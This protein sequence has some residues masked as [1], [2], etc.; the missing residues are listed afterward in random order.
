MFTRR[1]GI[2]LA[3][4]LFLGTAAFLA[5]LAAERDPGEGWQA[6]NIFVPM[7]SGYPEI[8]VILQESRL[9][10]HP[11]VFRAL[12]LGTATGRHLQSGEYA[13]PAPP[14]AFEVWRKLVRGEVAR[15]S[16]TIPEGSN[17]HD[18]AKILGDS[19]L[20]DPDA[21]V[22]AARSAELAA[23]LDVPGDTVEGFLFPD[24]Y[25]LVKYM[26][27]NEIIG[28]MVRQFRRRLAPG[29]EEKG[30]LAGFSLRQIVT[31]ASII[32]KETGVPEEKPLVSAVIRRR[33][34][35]GMP[36]QMDPTVI[37]GLEKFG[38][39]LT[40]KDL[41]TP[42]PYNTYLRR[43]LP[44]GPITNPGLASLLA[45]VSP[46]DADYLYFVSRNDGSHEFSKSLSDH[47][48]AVAAFRKTTSV[49]N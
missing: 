3:L 19:D 18:I 41:R 47:N 35:I 42:N 34:A 16:V 37:Y 14:S 20:A 17:I 23:R 33:L 28:I 36:L 15:Y 43:G 25:V 6:R 46:A 5:F 4:T 48:R 11:L 31:I 39:T 45:A 13:F 22:A 44:P 38:E 7:G 29:I 40:R 30:R 2:S 12:V 32:E 1:F 9:L 21:F 24:T 27:E 8:A 49:A 10:R 26:P